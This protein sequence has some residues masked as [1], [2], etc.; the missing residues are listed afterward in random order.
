MYTNSLTSVLLAEH[1]IIQHAVIVGTV[2]LALFVLVNAHA[3]ALVP[4]LNAL[5][6]KRWVLV[7]LGAHCFAWWLQQVGRF[8]GER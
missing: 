5:F 3:D 4:V 8:L 2:H 7:V 1:I 6:H